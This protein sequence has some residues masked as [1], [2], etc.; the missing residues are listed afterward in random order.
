MIP[1]LAEELKA[2]RIDAC[3][4]NGEFHT[5][6]TNGPLFHRP[7]TILHGERVFKDGC[8]VLDYTVGPL[9]DVKY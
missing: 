8:W 7:I 4:E 3:G 2:R 5:V 1:C 6:V 9:A